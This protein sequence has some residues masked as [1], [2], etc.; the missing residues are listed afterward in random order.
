MSDLKPLSYLSAKF[1]VPYLDFN[2]RF[3]LLRRCRAFSAMEKNTTIS[4]KRLEMNPHEIIINGVYYTLGVIQI[5]NNDETPKC[6]REMN[7]EGG[8]P[9]D[10]DQYGL[11][12]DLITENTHYEDVFLAA[13]RNQNH[14]NTLEE[15]RDEIKYRCPLPRRR[16]EMA[17][18]DD[19][20]DDL[21][22]KIRPVELE[23][24]NMRPPYTHYLQLIISS[25]R[26][27]S[28]EWVVYNQHDASLRK[29]MEYLFEKMIGRRKLYIRE[30]IPV[31]N[32]RQVFDYVRPVLQGSL[33]VLEIDRM[34]ATDVIVETARELVIKGLAVGIV[35]PGFTNQRIHF[36][37]QYNEN[38][39][40]LVDYCKRREVGLGKHY[41]I[42][43]KTKRSAIEAFEEY[44]DILEYF[45]GAIPETRGTPF[46]LCVTL[47]KRNELEINVYLEKA[48][49]PRNKSIYIFHAK[50]SPQGYCD[51][52]SDKDRAIEIKQNA[53]RVKDADIRPSRSDLIIERESNFNKIMFCCLTIITIF[54][55]GGVCYWLL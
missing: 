25:E 48:K 53:Y 40:F 27:K 10:V 42:E 11:R 3:S 4:I 41:S 12:N 34:V 51:E 13:S 18:L 43:M 33:T 50:I 23:R 54:I 16:L 37:E 14:I 49:D 44:F 29:A 21:R 47:P 26:G 8:L 52:I 39:S 5:Y 30:L 24:K 45:I 31:F 32:V 15:R 1:V 38:Y 55:I 2:I 35:L 22:S 7:R 9:Y 20:I 19:Q 36:R 6:I 28:Y 46:P 17:A